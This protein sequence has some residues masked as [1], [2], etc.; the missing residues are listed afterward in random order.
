MEVKYRDII[1][2]TRKKDVVVQKRDLDILRFL[3]EMKLS[4]AEQLAR[5]LFI[6]P[7][8]GMVSLKVVK[9]RLQ[10][11]A[12]ASLILAKRKPHSPDFFYRLSNKGLKYL[13]TLGLINNLKPKRLR[14]HEY[15]HDHRMVDFRLLL[16]RAHEFVSEVRVREHFNFFKGVTSI[17]DALYKNEDGAWVALEYERARKDKRRYDEKISNLVRLI[18]SRYKE[19]IT[20]KKIHIVCEFDSVFRQVK[21]I[22][23]VYQPIVLVETSKTFFSRLGEGRIHNERK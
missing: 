3:F 8:G 18:R 13:S 22:A 7:T 4:D 14:P 2:K 19:E 15:F 10:Y 21:D 9:R 5:A 17:P 16:A 6:K 12:D 23:E 20:F 11:L 1:Q